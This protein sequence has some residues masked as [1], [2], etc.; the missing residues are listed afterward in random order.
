MS[1]SDVKLN[2]GMTPIMNYIDLTFVKT[3]KQI[4]KYIKR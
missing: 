3:N 4:K 1:I 2:G